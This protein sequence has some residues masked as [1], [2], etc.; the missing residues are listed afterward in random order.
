MPANHFLRPLLATPAGNAPALVIA[1]TQAPLATTLEAAFDSDSRRRGL[2]GRSDLA[3]DTALIIAP[4]SAVHTLGMRF[5][6]DV[7]FAGRDGR[8]LK[9]AHAVRPRRLAVSWGAFATIEMAAGEAGRHGLRAGD[10][11]HVT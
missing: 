3:P 6:I 5:S 7:I 4:C 8:V 1:R 11:L 10:F 2:L 9:I